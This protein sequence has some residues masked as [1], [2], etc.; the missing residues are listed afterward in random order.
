MAEKM[1]MTVTGM[2]TRT[3]LATRKTLDTFGQYG[4]TRFNML[5]DLEFHLDK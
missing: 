4:F 5:L 3:N 2:V 1:L